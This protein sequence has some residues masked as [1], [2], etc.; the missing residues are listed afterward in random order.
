[1]ATSCTEVHPE[2]IFL[3][4]LLVPLAFCS[5][6]SLLRHRDA[7]SLWCIKKPGS[8]RSYHPMGQPWPRMID[9]GGYMPHVLS[10]SWTI[11]TAFC[12]DLQ[13]VARDI[14]PQ[15]LTEM[16]SLEMNLCIGFPFSSVLLFPV[17]HS[18]SVDSFPKI[19]Y[20]YTS[21]CFRLWIW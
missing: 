4:L 5:G 2:T 10:F 21:P 14:D 17:I 1:M 19:N 12:P 6:P 9:A 13:R 16:I 11:L 3:P 18:C 20:L 15:V 7:Q 8:V